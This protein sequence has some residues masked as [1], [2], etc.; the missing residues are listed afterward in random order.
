MSLAVFLP[1]LL[2]LGICFVPV[3]LL[4][5]QHDGRA[6]D[7]FISSQYTPPEVIRNSSIAKGLRMA[8]FG[9]FFA[10]GARGD[11]WPVV[12]GAACFGLGL[13][14]VYALRGPILKFLGN[15]LRHDQSITVHEF[16]ARRHG[17][18]PRVRLAAA[19]LTLFALVAVVAGETFAVTAFLKLVFGNE[20]AH[21]LMLAALLLMVLYA[22]PAGHSGTMHSGQ[23]QLG[24]LY[25]GLFGSTALLLY[26][27]VS[28]LTPLP[29]HGTFAVVFVAAC[30]ASMLVY[31]RSR[32][33]DTS[34]TGPVRKSSGAKLLRKFGKILNPCISVF[35]V[36]IV[37]LALME[38]YSVGVSAIAHG[39]ATALQAGTSMSGMG[40]IALC[41]LPLFQPLADITN[42]QRLAAAE[43]DRDFY[44]SDQE[45]WLKALRN[46]FRIYALESPLVWLFM[47]MFGA[48]AVA[49][50]EIPAGADVMQTFVR[51]L[52]SGG[53]PVA[54]I[55]GSLLLVAV[56]AL[57]LPAMSSA[58][59]ASLCTIRYDI[60]PAFSQ[61][62][63]EGVAR[64]HT[65]IVGAALFL[66]I[67]A[68]SYLAGTFLQIN[69]ASSTF[70][71]LIFAIGSPPLAFAPLIVGPSIARKGVSPG[72][73]L[74]ILGAGAASSVGGLTGYLATGNDLWLWAAVPACLGSGFLLF[75]AAQLW[76]RVRA[77]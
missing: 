20:A 33:V 36:L 63:N 16:I 9:P 11:F 61:P 70:L 50:M 65:L 21:F 56:A 37:V 12:A 76:R 64:R 6:Q 18:D 42:W 3:W 49:A 73:A 32:Y 59:S 40:L 23:W 45:R 72:W 27:H 10:F 57:A 25:L 74:L 38:F 14:L 17:N 53:N 46:V 60:L 75:A 34:P 62:A 71:A 30:C 5:R 26:L 2:S 7:Y 58:F 35:V 31:R 54:G 69:F 29:P 19:S 43:K 44:K 1:L 28:A 41:L 13:Y 52:A 24:M 67:A 4:R 15:A 68:I 66:V 22:V 51:E 8:S 48:L 47:A 39:S 77:G 55:A